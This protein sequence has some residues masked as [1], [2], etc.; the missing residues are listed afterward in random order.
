M[1]FAVC[2][3]VRCLASLQTLF[4]PSHPLDRHQSTHSR[5]SHSRLAHAVQVDDRAHWDNNATK[6]F[7]VIVHKKGG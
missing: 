6:N 5:H 7:Q 4:V 1:E 3:E 2:A